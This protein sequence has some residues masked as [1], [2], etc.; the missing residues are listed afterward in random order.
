VGFFN[1]AETA[2]VISIRNLA[3]SANVISRALLSPIKVS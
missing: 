3:I 1:L 2:E